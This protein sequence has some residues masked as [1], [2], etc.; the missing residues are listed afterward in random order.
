MNWF[1]GIV[2]YVMIWWISLFTVL[3]FGTQ[4][5]ADH[6]GVPGGWRGAPERPRLLL[7]VAVTTLL[8][9]LIWIGCYLLITSPYLSFRTGALAIPAN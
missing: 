5:V 8:A 4:P 9:A 1:T 7:K 3:P 6:Q 2:L